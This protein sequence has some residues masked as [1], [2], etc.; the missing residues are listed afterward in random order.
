[1][2]C[3]CPLLFM[4]FYDLHDKYFF[5]L[6]PNQYSKGTNIIMSKLQVIPFEVL[7]NY[8]NILLVFIHIFTSFIGVSVRFDGGIDGCHPNVFR[9][10][11][12]LI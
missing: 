11:R 3:H 1:M 8:T 9:H 4:F 6:I 10:I 12:M 5:L 7:C 2:W